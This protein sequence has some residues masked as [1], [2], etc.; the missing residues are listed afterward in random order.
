M[1][2]VELGRLAVKQAAG[3]EVKEFAEKMITDHSKADRKLEAWRQ[4]R[5]S[6]I[7]RS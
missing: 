5:T 3:S 6:L 1:A 2:E 7:P 4:R